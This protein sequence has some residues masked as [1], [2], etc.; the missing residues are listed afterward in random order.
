MQGFFLVILSNHLK[1]KHMTEKGTMITGKTADQF[2]P[3]HFSSCQLSIDTLKLNNTSH[4]HTIVLSSYS[5]VFSAQGL[6]EMH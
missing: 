4:V 5:N 3:N 6:N 2:I 1:E